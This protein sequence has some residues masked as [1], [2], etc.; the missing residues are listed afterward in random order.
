MKEM[1]LFEGLLRYEV[2]NFEKGT[3][4]L[5]PELAESWKQ[6]D[7]KTLEI[8]LRQGVKFHDGTDLNAEVAKWV[9][10]RMATAPKSLS[11]RLGE[12]FDKIDVVD[13]Y[14]LKISYKR[15]SALQA[16]NLTLATAGT[17]SIGPAMVSKKNIE[18]IGEEA[19]GQGKVVGTGPFKMAQFKKD[20]EFTLAK[21]DGYWKMGDDAQKLPYLDGV[22]YRLISDAAVQ[23]VELKAG[24]LHT[25]RSI[26]IPMIPSVKADPNFQVIQ[27]FWSPNRWFSGFNDKK[28]P[29]GTNLKLRQATQ[30]ATDRES[31]AK[32]MGLEFGWPGYYVG[33]I[34]AWSGYDE[35]LPHYTFDLN[36]AQQLVKESGADNLNIEYLHY[37]PNTYKQVAEML[38]QMWGKVG[39]KMTLLPAEQAAAREKVKSGGFE[40]SSWT[41]AP[42]PDPAHFERMFTCDGAANWN[43][44]CSK[45]ADKCMI[46]AQAEMDPVKRANDYKTCQKIFYEDAQLTNMFNTPMFQVSRKEVKNLKMQIH[47]A[48]VQEVWLDK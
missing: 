24:T 14:T 26:A 33:W 16:L 4:E 38:Q 2:T 15:P 31:M 6:V 27:V 37:L 10:E 30:Y 13:P 32:V 44:Y 12:N 43:N 48:D 9:L 3:Q 46:D 17:G 18:T 25:T 19:V 29:F 5:K 42:S 45:D 41:M 8:K 28:S 21:F 22:R 7:S 36:K 35:S 20:D 11:K 1:G 40:F 39:V 47:S 34:P 23:L